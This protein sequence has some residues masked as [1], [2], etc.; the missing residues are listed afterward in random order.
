[1]KATPYARSPRSLAPRI[2]ALPRASTASP[3]LEALIQALRRLDD[4]EA[5]DQPATLVLALAQVGRCYRALGEGAT[6]EWYLQQGLRKARALAAPEACIELLCDLAELLCAVADEN[7]NAEHRGGHA[8][9]ERARDHGF[10]ATQLAGEAGDP[11]WE[12]SVLLRVGAVF[13]RC[14]DMDDAL[15]L[16]ARAVDLRDSVARHLPAMATSA[17]KSTAQAGFR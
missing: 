17:I 12:M 15:A 9:R 14:G 11:A 13:E 5:L 10:E 7:E 6:A 3:A 1:M 8:A 2:P 16:R 4:A